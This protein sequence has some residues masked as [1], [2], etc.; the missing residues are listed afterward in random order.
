MEPSMQCATGPGSTKPNQLSQPRT[1]AVNQHARNPNRTPQ[2]VAQL[3]LAQ[4]HTEIGARLHVHVK[5]RGGEGPVHEPRTAQL[6]GVGP[7]AFAL[8]L[9][10]ERE[11]LVQDDLNL[12]WGVEAEAL[13]SME[14]LE[15]GAARRR[16]VRVVCWEREG[17]VIV[18]RV[19][20]GGASG[21]EGRGRT[22]T[23][24]YRRGGE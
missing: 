17:P 5:R 22:G 20:G 12:G 3:H 11:R 21:G 18:S 4:S 8:L 1:A 9:G 10:R 13:G 23:D 24:Q 15:A 6:R 14:P 19:A 7:A 2:H 16:A